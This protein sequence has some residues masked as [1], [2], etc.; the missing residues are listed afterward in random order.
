MSLFDISVSWQAN[1]VIG[2]ENDLT[3]SSIGCSV[4]LSLY[5]SFY[6]FFD[7]SIDFS[8]YLACSTDSQT[9]SVRLSMCLSSVCLK[10]SLSKLVH[11]S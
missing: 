5:L 2:L 9:V 3:V 1:E 4:D 10:S 6:Q 8:I 11:L 7:G